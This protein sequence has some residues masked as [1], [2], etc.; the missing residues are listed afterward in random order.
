[1]MM[2]AKVATHV[3]IAWIA[4]GHVSIGRRVRRGWHVPVH[5]PEQTYGKRG[6]FR[7]LV[8]VRTAGES[9]R[10]GLA[11][12][13]SIFLQIKQAF[14]FLTKQVHIELDPI[15]KGGIFLEVLCMIV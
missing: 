3:R 6:L 4:R 10:E 5:V 8:Q 2:K 14:H 15:S 9:V 11:M 1:M 12:G 13:L 7:F